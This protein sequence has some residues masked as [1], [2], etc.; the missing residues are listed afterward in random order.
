MNATHLSPILAGGRAHSTMYP[1]ASVD[2]SIG[3][4]SRK[5]RHV[6][7]AWCIS[8]QQPSCR[9]CSKLHSWTHGQRA[10]GR[11]DR[12]GSDRVRPSSRWR[13][14]LPTR[15]CL[16]PEALPGGRYLNGAVGVP[17]GDETQVGAVPKDGYL[18]PRCVGDS[19]QQGAAVSLLG[20]SAGNTRHRVSG[21][22]RRLAAGEAGERA[23]VFISV[24]QS[25]GDIRRVSSVE[26]GSVGGGEGSSDSSKKKVQEN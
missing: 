25:E 23:G 1:A 2:R 8:S 3:K 26:R 24:P 14:Q 18:R 13:Q 21:R 4:G 17:G 9:A 10:R 22:S 15:L 11:S 6:T 16:G 12:R 7:G 20:R 19:A 5:A